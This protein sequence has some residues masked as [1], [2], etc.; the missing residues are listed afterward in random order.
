MSKR[1]KI[2]LIAVAV[3]LIV[4]AAMAYAVVALVWR[5]FFIWG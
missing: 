1:T 3:W 4:D 5:G 2:I